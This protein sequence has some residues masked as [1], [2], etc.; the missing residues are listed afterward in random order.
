MGR[1]QSLAPHIPTRGGGGGGGGRALP[2]SEIVGPK[3]ASKISFS[4]RAPRFGVYCKEH[5][6]SCTISAANPPGK[7]RRVWC[8]YVLL[9]K[10][11]LMLRDIVGHIFVCFFWGG[12]SGGISL[13]YCLTLDSTERRR[14]MDL[15][16][17]Y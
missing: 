4:C 12:A 10:T 5:C 1:Y 14:L 17:T 6:Q 9:P 13:T 3:D 16:D 15:I 11:A 7:V 2:A 8:S